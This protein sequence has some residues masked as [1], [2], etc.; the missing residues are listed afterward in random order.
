MTWAADGRLSKKAVPTSANPMMLRSYYCPERHS[1]SSKMGVGVGRVGYSM[2]YTR[3]E[4]IVWF[5]EAGWKAASPTWQQWCLE[6]NTVATE[7]VEADTTRKCLS[8]H[9]HRKRALTTQNCMNT[10]HYQLYKNLCMWTKLKGK[11]PWKVLGEGG[12]NLFKILIQWK[13]LNH[14]LFF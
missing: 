13:K 1:G 14:F 11:T 5:R 10:N 3:K 8:F 4:H 9:G 6:W 7:Q 12:H 2:P